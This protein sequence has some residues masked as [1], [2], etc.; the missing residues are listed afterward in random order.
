MN[1][2]MNEEDFV[3]L[4]SYLDR[5]IDTLTKPIPSTQ[6]LRLA[7]SI[8]SAKSSEMVDED[9]VDTYGAEDYAS[10][11][12]ALGIVTEM[13][14]QVLANIRGKSIDPATGWRFV[15]VARTRYGKCDLCAICHE[16]FQHWNHTV[17]VHCIDM[18]EGAYH[19][20]CRECVRTYAPIEFIDVPGLE[21]W[22]SKNRSVSEA[23]ETDHKTE[24]QRI[25]LIDAVRRFAHSTHYFGKF[26]DKCPEWLQD[27]FRGEW[28]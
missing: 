6:V 20:V 22:V 15:P 26:F 3:E 24:S 8:R 25:A 12:E 28:R 27:A 23:I 2:R 9:A 11:Q 1:K 13:L 10:L 4:V 7:E 5:R 18:H 19:S 16:P 17:E 14:P 21:E